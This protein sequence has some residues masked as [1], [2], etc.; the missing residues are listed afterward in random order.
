MSLEVFAQLTLGPGT[1]LQGCT[2]FWYDLVRFGCAA[3]WRMRG[4]A[5]RWV[6]AMRSRVLRMLG[7]E[8]DSGTNEVG[9]MRLILKP[10]RREQ[11]GCGEG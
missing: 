2:I 9:G 1:M 10:M 6:W 5:A 4:A 7:C 11:S 3:T 8:M